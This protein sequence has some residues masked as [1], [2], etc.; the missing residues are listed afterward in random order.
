MKLID[1][2]RPFGGERVVVYY[3]AEDR[4][5][6]RQLV[7]DLAKEFQT[8]I[9]M[10]QIGVRRRGEAAGRLRRL[11][12]TGLLQHPPV[13]NAAWSMRMAKL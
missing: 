5:D 4:I 3:L 1:I 7:K 12:Q 2:E 13:G 11:R 8:R 9:E 10:R 6:F